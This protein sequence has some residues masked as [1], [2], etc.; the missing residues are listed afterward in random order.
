MSIS[1]AH[2]R[3]GKIPG[4]VKS[5]AHLVGLHEDSEL[6]GAPLCQTTLPYPFYLNR[7]RKEFKGDLTYFQTEYLLNWLCAFKEI[8][9]EDRF[10][11]LIQ[12]ISELKYQYQKLE[13]EGVTPQ[14]DALVLD[15][16]LI[17]PNFGVTKEQKNYSV[18]DLAHHGFYGLHEDCYLCQ[19]ISRVRIEEDQTGKSI[20]GMHEH[21]GNILIPNKFPVF[22]GH[23]LIVPLEHHSDPRA[24]GRINHYVDTETLE[25]VAEICEAFHLVSWMNSPSGGMSIPPHNHFHTAPEAMMIPAFQG[26]SPSDGGLIVYAHPNSYVDIT[27]ISSPDKKEMI[28][29]VKEQCESLERQ[30]LAFNLGYTR[31]SWLV[32]KRFDTDYEATKSSGVLIGAPLPLGFFFRT[33]G[34]NDPKFKSRMAQAFYPT[35]N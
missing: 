10:H 35:S 28:N 33:A 32:I 3:L 21:S 1:R 15:R 17:G 8:S 2:S 34:I 30:R 26:I 5:H 16:K 27:V 20:I 25:C 19:T 22:L 29:A 14:F 13:V 24:N 7:C 12:E 9:D 11:S 23:G 6:V 31:G 4:E 18:A